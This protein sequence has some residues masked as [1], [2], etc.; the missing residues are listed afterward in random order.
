M[1]GGLAPMLKTPNL[2]VFLILEDCLLKL[3]EK[4]L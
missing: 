4:V 1:S 2:G 3:A